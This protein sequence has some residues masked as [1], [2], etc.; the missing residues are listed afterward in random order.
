MSALAEAMA[1][2]G[3]I[4]RATALVDV[5]AEIRSMMLGQRQIDTMKGERPVRTLVDLGAGNITL[6]ITS[7]T[8]VLAPS[9]AT[10]TRTLNA[11]ASVTAVKVAATRWIISGSG[12][13]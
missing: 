6:E 12:I 1:T 2:K 8:L 7:D 11:P 10:G 13:V 9:G 5:A 3:E 4:E